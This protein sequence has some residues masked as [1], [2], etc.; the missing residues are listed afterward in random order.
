[1]DLFTFISDNGLRIGEGGAFGE[2]QPNICT[3]V[4]VT[5]VC[6]T[7]ANTMLTAVFFTGKGQNHGVRNLTL[8]PDCSLV[9]PV[10]SP[11]LAAEANP[12]TPT[13]VKKSNAP[14]KKPKKYETPPSKV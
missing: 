2:R 3:N 14:F 1:M 12:W 13:A 10:I 4:E 6:P 11:L 8:V 7:I 9:S 5:T